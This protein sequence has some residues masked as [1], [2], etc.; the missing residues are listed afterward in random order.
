ML[1]PE[2][3]LE[4]LTKT[5]HR[6]NQIKQKA[7]RPFSRTTGLLEGEIEVATIRQSHYIHSQHKESGR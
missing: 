4:S 6:C 1:N 3:G 5:G 2:E 7:G